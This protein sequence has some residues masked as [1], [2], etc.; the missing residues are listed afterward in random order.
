MGRENI[1]LA[2]AVARVLLIWSMGWWWQ[3]LVCH[4]RKPVSHPWIS[5]QML[6]SGQE[7]KGV[8]ETDTFNMSLSSWAIPH[9]AGDS[10]YFCRSKSCM[11]VILLIARQKSSTKRSISGLVSRSWRLTGHHM[12]WEATGT[13]GLVPLWK[14]TWLI[15]SLHMQ[16]CTTSPKVNFNSTQKK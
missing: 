10:S 2:D 16:I 8:G 5:G 4:K 7:S 1:Q 3:D 15:F 12:S 9:S 14:E 6:F 13:K 11:A